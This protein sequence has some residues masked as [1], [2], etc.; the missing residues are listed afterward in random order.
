MRHS[1]EMIDMHTGRPEPGET[2]PSY[3]NTELQSVNYMEEGLASF[4]KRSQAITR[5][6]SYSC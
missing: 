2:F 4:N 3:H 1:K 6:G 5:G